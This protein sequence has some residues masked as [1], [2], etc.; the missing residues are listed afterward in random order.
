MKAIF[1]ALVKEVKSKSLVSGDKAQRIILEANELSPEI[2]DKIYR[3]QRADAL[4]SVAL[5]DDD[6]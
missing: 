4:V 2:M 5:V 1:Q 6:G 3:L